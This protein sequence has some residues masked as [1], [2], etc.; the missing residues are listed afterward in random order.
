[1]RII[2]EEPENGCEDEIIIRCHSLDEDIMKLIHTLKNGKDKLT[3]YSDDGI[4]MLSM[5]EIFYFESVDNKVFAYCE[6]SV[7]EIKS[8]LYELEDKY[9]D[10]DFIRVSK[11][12]IANISKIEKLS[13]T[14]NGR[15]TANL[16]NGEKIIISRQY[17]PDFKKKLGLSEG[18]R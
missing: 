17:V 8:K 13:P 2:I 4:I 7:Y 14:L 12:V 3:A 9:S 15:F 6:K 11:S 18:D 10:T 16:A 5:N 1:M